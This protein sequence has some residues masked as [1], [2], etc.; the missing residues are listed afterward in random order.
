MKKYVILTLVL[1]FGIAILSGMMTYI[2]TNKKE[3]NNTQN[4]VGNVDNIKQKEI[5]TVNEKEKI[6]IDENN[7]TQIE[8]QKN[9][10]TPV[11]DSKTENKNI[12]ISTPQV[13]D[14]QTIAEENNQNKEN[15]NNT[16]ISTKEEKIQIHPKQEV[17]QEKKNDLGEEYKTNDAMITTIKNVINSNQSE[18]MKR[19]G[20][21]IV[22][23]SSIV[24]ITSQFTYTAQRVID[25]IKYKFGTIKIYVRDYYNNGEFI[26]TQCYII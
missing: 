19:Y 24:N 25:K 14:K 10:K 6:V 11:K 15:T 18:D 1:I 20:Y 26:C 9:E 17:K 12:E 16:P 23:D 2:K 8:K 21:N 22:I 5:N 4:I 3:D 13:K 7:K